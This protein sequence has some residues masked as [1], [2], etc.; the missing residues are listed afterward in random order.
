[1]KKI[2]CR[3]EVKFK[4]KKYPEHIEKKIFKM[5]FSKNILAYH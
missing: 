5:L 1:M 4:R 2:F 3:N